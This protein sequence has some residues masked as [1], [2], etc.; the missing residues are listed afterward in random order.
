L[1]ATL[2]NSGKTVVKKTARV[3]LFFLPGS[4]PFFYQS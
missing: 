4:G 2:M 3:V 1:L